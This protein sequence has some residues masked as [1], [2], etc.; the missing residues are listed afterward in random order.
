MKIALDIGHTSGR[1]QGAVSLCGL[2]EHMYW[3]RH[4]HIIKKILEQHFF[5]VNIYRRE[6]YGDS[7][8]AECRAVNTWGANAAVSLHLNSSDNITAT[9]HEVIHY[10]GS[11]NG[12]SLAR[13]INEQ[14]NFIPEL[15]DRNIRTPFSG[16]G[17]TWLTVTK[18]PAV[19]VEAGFLSNPDDVKILKEKGF[20]IASFIATGV[21]D[22]F[23]KK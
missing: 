17:N 16:R 1:D 11:R 20:E 23:G 21:I 7:I 18:C 9:G 22:Y 6:D 15:R 5:N 10:G 3:K 19:I 2:T 14:L 13:S 4:V 12:A 8:S